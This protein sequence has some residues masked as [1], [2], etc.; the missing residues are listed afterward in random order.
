M[1]EWTEGWLGIIIVIKLG[2]GVVGYYKLGPGLVTLRIFN[3]LFS[4]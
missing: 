3:R 2:Q 4:L 1:K